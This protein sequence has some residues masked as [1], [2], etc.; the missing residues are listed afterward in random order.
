M[1]PSKF[2]LWLIDLY[3]KSAF[4]R[5]LPVDCNYEPSCSAYA[6]QAVE[7]HGSWKGVMLTAS[8]LRRCKDRDAF[9]KRSDPVPEKSTC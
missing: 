8:R 2:L 1:R 4:R 6:K 5:N 3:R 7:R 9:K